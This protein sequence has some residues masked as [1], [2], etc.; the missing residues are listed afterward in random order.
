MARDIHTS[1]W[2]RFCL[3]LTLTVLGALAIAA[4]AEYLCEVG[5]ADELYAVTMGFGV[6]ALGF[7]AFQAY[8][9][10]FDSLVEARVRERLGEVMRRHAAE[11]N[12]LVSGVDELQ[13]ELQALRSR[14]RPGVL[15]RK[16]PVRPA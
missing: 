12:E 14:M 10:Y 16:F 4:V 15:E 2:P 7:T 1:K 5:K 13:S 9:Q 3:Y 11:L 8:R 6:L